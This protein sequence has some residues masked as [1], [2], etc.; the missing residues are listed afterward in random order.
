MADPT[1]S[2]EGRVAQRP[3]PIRHVLLLHHGGR[4]CTDALQAMLQG[5]TGHADMLAIVTTET[6]ELIG[7]T[8]GSTSTYHDVTALGR[9]PARVIP[10]IRQFVERHGRRRPMVVVT[11]QWWDQ[12]DLAERA[13]LARHEALTNLAFAGNDVTLVC[14][15]DTRHVTSGI[16]ADAKRNHPVLADKQGL[17]P[18]PWFVDPQAMLELASTPLEPAPRGAETFDVRPQQLSEL[19][20]LVEERGH[21]AGLASD[22]VEDLVLAANELATNVV[23]HGHGDGCLTIWTDGPWLVCEVVDRGRLDDPFV[24]TR[25]PP[26]SN[27]AGRGLFMVNQLCDLVELRSDS[28]G[29]AVRLRFARPAS[30][31]STLP[32]QSS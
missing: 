25:P 23:S 27:T 24:G 28:G 11:E 6:H 22:R 18:N 14:L 20:A 3:S 15:Y 9:N 21:A 12:R 2:A 1:D 4:S 16:V 31:S 10:A 13:E 17:R 7:S 19:R 5:E 32:K 26:T 29:T 30:V 8:L